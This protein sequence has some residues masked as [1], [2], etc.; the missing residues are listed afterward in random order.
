[1][2]F[3]SSFDR[4]GNE[5][6]SLA[7]AHLGFKTPDLVVQFHKA[8]NGHV[9]LDGKGNEFKCS[10]EISPFQKVPRELGSRDPRVNTLEAGLLH[11][12]LFFEIFVFHHFSLLF[13]LFF[14]LFFFS[15]LLIFF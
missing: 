9:F 12:H 4:T 3:F 11:F 6:S 8:F 10:V 5:L 15:S 1:M 7:R 14:V 2:F 13:L